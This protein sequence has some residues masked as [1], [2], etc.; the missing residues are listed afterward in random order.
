MDWLGPALVVYVATACV[1]AARRRL[2]RIAALRVRDVVGLVRVIRS[3]E[4]NEI[5]ARRAG[6]SA[7]AAESVVLTALVSDDST[8][9]RIA[10]VNEVLGDLERELTVGPD[11]GRTI[12]RAALLSG[13]LACVLELAMTVAGPGGPAWLPSGTSFLI[14]LA[15]WMVSLELGR[16]VENQAELVRG[17]W[18]KV[19]LAVS[20]RLTGG[21]SESAAA[22]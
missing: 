14:G 13:T 17:E 11:R 18:D 3:G 9:V 22:H 2:T 8:A 16:R 7:E 15:G 6:M 21:L 5:E 4:R 12:G 19:A 20:D 1:V 10:T